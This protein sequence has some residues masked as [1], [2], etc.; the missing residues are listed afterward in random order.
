[1]SLIPEDQSKQKVGIHLDKIRIN[2]T[3]DGKKLFDIFYRGLTKN[4]IVPFC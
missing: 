3:L 4:S 1:M 2:Y